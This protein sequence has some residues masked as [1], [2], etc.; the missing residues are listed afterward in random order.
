MSYIANRFQSNL[1]FNVTRTSSSLLFFSQHFTSSDGDDTIG[2]NNDDL[3]FTAKTGV[4]I[5][6]FFTKKK[7][8]EHIQFSKGHLCIIFDENYK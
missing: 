6:R 1:I 3:T 8:I 4:R 2:R 7:K 5:Y